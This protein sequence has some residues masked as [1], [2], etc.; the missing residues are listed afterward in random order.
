MISSSPQ[1][2]VILLYARQKC[3]INEGLLLQNTWWKQ[4]SSWKEAMRKRSQNIELSY[5][6]WQ[7]VNGMNNKLEIG[8]K[9]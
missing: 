3:H 8:I 7:A 4:K 2:C 1:N 6:V 9:Y 5:A